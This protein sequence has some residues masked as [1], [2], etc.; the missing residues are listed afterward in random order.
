LA[1]VAA[2]GQSTT[3]TV[4]FL[5]VEVS[6]VESL[7]FWLSIA[8]GLT[9][10]DCASRGNSGY[11]RSGFLA[12]L[13]LGGPPQLLVE[14]VDVAGSILAFAGLQGLLQLP[15]L[16]CNLVPRPSAPALNGSFGRPACLGTIALVPDLTLKSTEESS[17][18]STGDPV[19]ADSFAIVTSSSTAS[20]GQS[21]ARPLHAFG[22]TILSGVFIPS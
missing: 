19:L 17:M 11:V 20:V 14:G 8:D 15:G 6:D 9:L 5:A 1:F 13:L 22:L 16:L 2:P 4:T 12:A 3:A 7:A 21:T 18:G 10:L